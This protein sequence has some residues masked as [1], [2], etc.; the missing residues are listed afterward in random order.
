MGN[1]AALKM[2]DEDRVRRRF[3][4]A[5]LAQTDRGYRV[6]KCQLIWCGWLS[7]NWCKTAAAA[8]L[9]AARRVASQTLR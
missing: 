9:A 4:Q 6:R 5:H 8:W 7:K 3:P 2:T 1:A